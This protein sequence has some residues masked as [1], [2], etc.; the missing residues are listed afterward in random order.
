[1]SRIS[2]QM[3]SLTSQG[4]GPRIA[5][6]VVRDSMNQVRFTGTRKIEL[7]RSSE[8]HFQTQESAA[9]V[10]WGSEAQ[11]RIWLDVSRE[12]EKGSGN[13]GQMNSSDLSELLQAR[14]R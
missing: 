4:L 6:R 5:Y 7:G 9:Q 10:A 14:E 13:S 3:N 2:I 11:I 12:W 1:M 8:V